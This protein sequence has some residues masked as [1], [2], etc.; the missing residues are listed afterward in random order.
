MIV[1]QRAK[2]A[3]AVRG[4]T[5]HYALKQIRRRHWVAHAARTGLGES[6][7]QQLIDESIAQ[8]PDVIETAGAQLPHG[9]PADLFDAVAQGLRDQ[10]ALLSLA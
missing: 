8:V 1:P 4:T 3:M 6:L 5:N 7:A 9:F 10:A 2:L